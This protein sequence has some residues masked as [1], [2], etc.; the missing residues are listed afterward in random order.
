MSGRLIVAIFSTSLEETAIAVVVLWG[1]PQFE[2]YIPLPGLITLMVLWLAFSV[3]IYQAGSRALK[4]KPVFDLPNM[5]GSKGKVVSPLVPEGLIKIESELWM[6]KSRGTPIDVGTEVTV[7][8]Q[9]GLKLVV[10]RR[11][12]N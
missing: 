7:V 8:E 4:K 3:F 2:I 12:S 6:A 10:C 5:V 1:L 9:D 11:G